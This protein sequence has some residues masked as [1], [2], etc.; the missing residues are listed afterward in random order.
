MEGDPQIP[1]AALDADATHRPVRTARRVSLRSRAGFALVATLGAAGALIFVL[2]GRRGQFSTAVLTAPIWLLLIAA[3]LHLASLVTRSEAWNFCM[4]SAG[5]ST[6]R[7]VVFRAAGLGALASVLSAQLGVATRIGT[8]RRTAPNTT[9]KAPALVAVEVPIV[10]VEAML[11]ALFTFTLI[12]PLNLPAWTPLLVIAAMI[13]VLL[14]LRRVARR[15]RSGLW[16]GLAAVRELRGRGRLVALIVAGI[17][18]QIARNWLVLRAVGVDT[19]VLNAIAVLI[20]S[21]SLSPLPFGA[22]V[23][24]TATVLIL[25]SHGLADTAAAGVLLTVTGTVAAL[26]Y[27]AW[28]CGDHAFIA[29]RTRRAAAVI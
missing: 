4:R 14:A 6:P 29:V 2:V 10:A 26:C 22:G 16:G 17:L 27:A 20:V 3:L 28:A 18:A 21:V 9:P 24:A 11:A 12:G 19:S 23:G 7:R 5:G 8:I 25:G 15:R 1:V 13:G